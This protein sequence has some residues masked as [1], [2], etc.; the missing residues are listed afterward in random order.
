MV[1]VRKSGES[2][3]VFCSKSVKYGSEEE[4]QPLICSTLS[5]NSG[6]QYN[7]GGKVHTY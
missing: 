6:P 1:D 2:T 7:T 5:S 4:K 3:D